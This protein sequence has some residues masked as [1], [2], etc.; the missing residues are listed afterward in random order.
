MRV[1]TPISSAHDVHERGAGMLG[2]HYYNA[3]LEEI[4]DRYQVW[5]LWS[6]KDHQLAFRA[7]LEITARLNQLESDLDVVSR[8]KS[9]S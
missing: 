4:G 3:E 1:D 8:Y 9:R 2:L 5:R 6:E 7:A